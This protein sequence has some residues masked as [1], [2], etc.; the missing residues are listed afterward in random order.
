MRIPNKIRGIRFGRHGDENLSVVI[1]DGVVTVNGISWRFELIL[2]PIAEGNWQ[3]VH[4][5]GSKLPPFRQ[6]GGTIDFED[7]TVVKMTFLIEV[8]VD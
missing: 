8:V 4:L 7:F 3:L 2:A 6:G 5:S 1:A